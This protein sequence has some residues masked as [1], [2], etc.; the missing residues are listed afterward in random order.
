MHT[1][2][3]SLSLML[4]LPFS[5]LSP[6][7][8]SSLLISPHIRCCSDPNQVQAL[9]EQALSAI[10]AEAEG[11]LA[12]IQQSV[13]LQDGILAEIM[14]ENAAFTAFRLSDPSTVERDRVLKSIED[15]TSKVLRLHNQLTSGNTFYSNLQVPGC[16]HPSP[17]I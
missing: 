11:A 4:P 9:S 16:R 2:A 17:I 14:V 8:A 7:L 1:I 13:Q 12:A 5:I 10:V 15:S 6:R 3:L